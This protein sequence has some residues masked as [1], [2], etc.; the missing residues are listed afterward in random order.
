[1]R[2]VRV[3]RVE[4]GGVEVPHWGARHDVESKGPEDAKVYRCVELLHEPR[5]FCP[6][7]DAEAERD[8]S[9]HAL[10]EELTRE[11]EDDNVECHKGKVGAAFSILDWCVG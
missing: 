7:S 4:G 3:V 6:R 9:D 10:H 1:M 8:G 11:G 5:L 2:L